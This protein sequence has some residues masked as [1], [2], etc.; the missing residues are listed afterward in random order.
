VDAPLAV[1]TTP[2]PAQT[3]AG[4]AGLTLTVGGVLTVMVTLF[5]LVQLLAAVPITV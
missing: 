1:N 3:G 5:V 4:V 2:L